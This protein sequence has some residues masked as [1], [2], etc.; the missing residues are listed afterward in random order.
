MDFDENARRYS[1]SGKGIGST[2]GVPRN[3]SYPVTED[4]PPLIRNNIVI[5]LGTKTDD[6]IK[7]TI[8]NVNKYNLQ[9]C[10]LFVKIDKSISKDDKGCLV[11]RKY[12]NVSK[13]SS[14]DD[15]KLLREPRESDL[16]NIPKLESHPKL[17]NIQ[18]Q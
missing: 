5:L 7:I 1:V 10:R 18:Y 11:D 2:K 12:T 13:L 9:P 17:I 8:E 14:I 15:I 4:L 3:S 16:V 6:L